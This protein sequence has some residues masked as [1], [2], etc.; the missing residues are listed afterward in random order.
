VPYALNFVLCRGRPNSD[1]FTAEL[2]YAPFGK[3]GFSFLTTHRLITM[4]EMPVAT[5]RCF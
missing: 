1:G 5:T 2:D 3:G 4:A